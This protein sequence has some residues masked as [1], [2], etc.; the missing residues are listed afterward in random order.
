MAENPR[1]ELIVGEV[2]LHFSEAPI[3]GN[4]ISRALLL[5]TLPDL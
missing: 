1:D 4:L 3:W 2:I 5:P